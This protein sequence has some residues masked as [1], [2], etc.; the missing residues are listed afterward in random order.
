[1]GSKS[2]DIS[3]LP[4]KRNS[5]KTPYWQACHYCIHYTKPLF[6]ALL[7]YLTRWAYIRKV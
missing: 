4:P 5:T 1:M 7:V 6:Y 2:F 3:R